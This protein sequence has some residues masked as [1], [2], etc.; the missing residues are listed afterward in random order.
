[1]L[2]ERPATRSAT[3]GAAAARRLH[4]RERGGGGGGVIVCV[5]ERVREGGG[6]PQLC[7]V[8]QRALTLT[9]RLPSNMVA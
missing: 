7:A 2:V 9:S 3:A 8:G 1:V 6:A 4:L 5:S